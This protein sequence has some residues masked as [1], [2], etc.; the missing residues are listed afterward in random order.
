[1]KKTFTPLFLFAF[2]LLAFSS[3]KKDVK[4]PVSKVQT[5]TSATQTFTGTQTSTQTTCTHTGIGTT[6]GS[7]DYN[8]G[9]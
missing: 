6:S 7:T 1:M 4:A 2:S 3:C 8:N 5:T 9:R